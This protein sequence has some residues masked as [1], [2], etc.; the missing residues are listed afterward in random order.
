M[1]LP[2]VDERRLRDICVRYG[3]AMLLVFGSAARGDDRDDSD[4]DVLY[5]LQP[6]ARLGWEIED[7]N[8][9][10]SDLFGRP[11]DLVSRKALHPLLKDA[12]LAESRPLYAA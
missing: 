12:V 8:K 11:V 1:I 3:I 10:L 4:I 5:E 6:G 9:D 2:R 7:L